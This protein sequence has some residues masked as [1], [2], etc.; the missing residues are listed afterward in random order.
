MGFALRLFLLFSFIPLARAAEI[1]RFMQ[2]S[3]GIYRGG[4]PTELAM[5]Q[6]YALGVKTIINLEDDLAQVAIESDWAESRGMGFQS[7]PMNGFW[8]PSDEKVD[9]ILAAISDPQNQPVFVHCY[10][11]EDRTGLIMGLFRYQF[12]NWTAKAA[13]AEMMSMGF[14]RLTLFPL[15]FYFRARTAKN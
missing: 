4:R 11:G 1:P 9:A 2:V 3:E 14:H 15:E 13:H 6:L 8:A 10:H 5:Q 12:E 7:F